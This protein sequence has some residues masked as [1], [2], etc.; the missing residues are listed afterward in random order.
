MKRTLIT[1]IALGF[2]ATACNNQQTNNE[3]PA[4]DTLALKPD[5][6]TDTV[7]DD[8]DDPAIWIDAN[9]PANSLIIGTDKHKENGGLYVFDLKGKIDAKRTITGLKRMNNVDIA[10]GLSIQ[11]QPVDIAVATERDRNSIRIFS[12][13]DMKAIDNGGIEVFRNDSLRLPMGIA[14]YKRP[15]DGA[16]F[17]IVGRKNGPTENYLEQYLLKDNGKG[18]VIGELVRKFGKF[19]GK[20]EIESIAVDQQLGYVYYSDEQTGIRK[21][22]A[23][24]SKGNE[25]LTL[26]G[27]GEFKEDNEGISIYQLT[28]STGYI[29]VS[30]QG[31]NRFN[32]YARE[33]S[34]TNPHEHKL[35]ASIPFS[36]LESDGSDVTAVSLPGFKGGL[37]VAMSTDKTFHYYSWEKIAQRAGLKIRE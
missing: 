37:F 16:I 21:Y 23:D 36:T 31:A 20:K 8:S 28:D 30:D 12:L 35:I 27:A 10:Y 5:V 6:I 4:T 13:P 18:Q 19:S 32:I 25:E 26:F 2:L 1:C 15:A 29:L 22:Y 33:G 24:P 7:F 14:L 9:N 17:A 3:E 11:G 34:K